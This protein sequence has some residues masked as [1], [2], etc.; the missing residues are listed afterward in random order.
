MRRSPRRTVGSMAPQKM[1]GV[2]HML[3]PQQTASRFVESLDGIW[4]F[5]LDD[6]KAFEEGWADSPLEDPMTMPVPSSYNDLKEG[7]GFRDFCG[8]AF[9]QRTIS[10]PEFAKTQRVMLRFSAVT[11]HAKV[12]I[13][14]ELVCEHVCG[15]C[16]LRSRSTITS[17]RATTCSRLPWTTISTTRPCLWAERTT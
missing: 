9:Y 10:V 8:W 12:Y 5:K 13:N 1:K 2:N 15:F 3:Y 6:G 7:V 17:N 11:H 16:P 14:G 4:D